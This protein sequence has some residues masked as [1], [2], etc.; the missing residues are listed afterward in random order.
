MKEENAI[1]QQEDNISQSRWHDPIDLEKWITKIQKSK[2]FSSFNYPVLFLGL[3]FWGGILGGVWFAYRG[4]FV[5][6][7][8]IWPLISLFTTLLVC[9]LFALPLFWDL[10]YA[11]WLMS[12]GHVSRSIS[13]FI[14]AVVA[15]SIYSRWLAKQIK[16]G[17]Y[18]QD[19]PPSKIKGAISLA[20]LLFVILPLLSKLFELNGIPFALF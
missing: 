15:Q 2:L 6:G 5:F 1:M 13:Q 18:K 14:L 12:L 8:F 4:R 20:L 9:L 16:A 3:S 11:K 10:S 17:K 19:A 7:T